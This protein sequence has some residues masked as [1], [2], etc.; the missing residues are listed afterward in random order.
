MSQFSDAFDLI[1]STVPVKMNAFF[2]PVP[3]ACLDYAS[4]DA[5]RCRMNLDLLAFCWPRID[6]RWFRNCVRR[7]CCD[8]HLWNFPCLRWLILPAARLILDEDL[9][10]S[11]SPICALPCHRTRNV[12]RELRRCV[13]DSS[14]VINHGRNKLAA[15]SLYGRPS[16]RAARPFWLRDE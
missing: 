5:F 2:R 7:P 4:S 3:S 10:T 9:G 1:L 12:L 13:G 8:H 6:G 11:W 15:M 14:L 16:D